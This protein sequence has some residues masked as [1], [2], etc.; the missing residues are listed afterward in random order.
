M[1]VRT[2]VNFLLA[3]CLLLGYWSRRACGPEQIRFYKGGSALR[4]G[5]QKDER[6]W[7]GQVSSLLLILSLLLPFAQLAFGSTDSIDTMV[8]A[9]CRAHGKHQCAMR[10]SMLSSAEPSSPQLAQV[11]EKCPCPPGLAPTTHSDPLWNH[12]HGFSEFHGRD[13][14]VPYVVNTS[15][16]GSSLEAAN[17]KRGPPAFSEH[18]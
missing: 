4:T 12:A 14:R 3:G 5:K 1:H 16:R 2:C 15:E 8:R 10:M 11:T 9:C 7:R 6:R 17:H 13:D 18:A